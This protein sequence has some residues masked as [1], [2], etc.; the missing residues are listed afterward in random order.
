M[1][2]IFF[3][4]MTLVTQWVRPRYNGNM[5][6]LEAQVRMLRSRIDTSKIVPTVEERA[7]LLR[8]GAD[9]DHDIDDVMHVVLP[10]TYKKWLRQLRGG[11]QF[12][13]SGRPRTPLPTAADSSAPESSSR[14]GTRPAS[15]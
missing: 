4:L 13:P 15:S 14:R 8:L 7:E 10:A 5:R 9:V 3:A 1:D 12:Q 2:A 11:K 6:L